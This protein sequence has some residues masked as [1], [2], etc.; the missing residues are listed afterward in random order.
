MTD[1]ERSLTCTP[2]STQP[3]PRPDA[4]RSTST[5]ASTGTPATRAPHGSDRSGDTWPVRARMTPSRLVGRVAE[6]AELELAWREVQDR[7]PVLVLLGGESGV[8]KTR[9]VTEFSQ[10]LAH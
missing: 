1:T 2:P 5:S 4:W 8:G 6:L 3:S 10:H 7:Q 9:L